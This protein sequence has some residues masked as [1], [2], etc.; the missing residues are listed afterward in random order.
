MPRR[1]RM[2]YGTEASAPL[3]LTIPTGPS[4]G[5]SSVNSVEK[6]STAPDWKFARPWE[7]GPTT[8]MPT[9]WA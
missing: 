9:R 8:R 5:G 1:R 7:F 4:A 3:W 6:P 2:P